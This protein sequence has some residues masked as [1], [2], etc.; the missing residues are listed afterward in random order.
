MTHKYVGYVAVKLSFP[1]KRWKTPLH[2]FRDCQVSEVDVM[3][4]NLFGLALKITLFKLHAATLP[5]NR[6]FQYGIDD[7][8]G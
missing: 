7:L 2:S 6:E 4:C 1:W 3:A 5:S 8:S